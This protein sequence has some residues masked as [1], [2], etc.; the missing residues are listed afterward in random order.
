MLL[1]SCLGSREASHG[2][3]EQLSKQGAVLGKKKQFMQ[4]P[5]FKDFYMLTMNTALSRYA[6]MT[7]I[8]YILH[9]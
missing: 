3:C 5:P 2:L 7:Q 9:G 1:E 4:K 8:Y 6:E